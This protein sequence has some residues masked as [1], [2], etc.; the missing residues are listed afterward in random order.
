M[1]GQ[2][3]D[4]E[5][6]SKTVPVPAEFNKSRAKAVLKYFNT[7]DLQ[8]FLRVTVTEFIL[9]LMSFTGKLF[10]PPSTTI[11]TPEA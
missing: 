11:S 7:V 5:A 10:K 6:V 2:N 8:S 9:P 1:L 3:T 4:D